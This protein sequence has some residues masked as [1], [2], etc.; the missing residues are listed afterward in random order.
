VTEAKA[1]EETD[2]AAEVQ[3]VVESPQRCAVV[4]CA[5]LF[6]LGCDLWVHCEAHA[7]CDCSAHQ[8]CNEHASSR[9]LTE[10]REIPQIRTR[11]VAQRILRG[12]SRGGPLR[13]AWL[14]AVPDFA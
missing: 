12:T 2:D 4:A 11:H 3:T 5:L 10:L 6:G 8:H 7:V 14:S 9:P 1:P 13:Q